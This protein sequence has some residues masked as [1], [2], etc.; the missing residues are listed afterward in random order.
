MPKPHGT[1]LK[2]QARE[3]HRQLAPVSKSLVTRPYQ[4]KVSDYREKLENVSTDRLDAWRRDMAAIIDSLKTGEPLTPQGKLRKRAADVVAEIREILQK[5]DDPKHLE[6]S[7]Q[8]DHR[9]II[10]APHDFRTDS[11]VALLTLCIAVF[12]LL[13]MW[14][15]LRAP[16]TEQDKVKPPPG[17]G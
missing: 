7:I 2:I 8:V 6:P 14:I 17:A 15:R 13:E 9:P 4:E 10:A 16:R 3:K 5:V 12:H 1:Y 11:P